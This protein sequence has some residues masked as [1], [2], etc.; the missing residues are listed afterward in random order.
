MCL[1]MIWYLT[2]VDAD[3]GGTWVVPWSHRDPRN[4]RGPVDN[5]CVAAPISGELQVAAPAGSVYIQD[6]RSWHASPLHNMGRPLCSLSGA[7]AA[8]AN[9]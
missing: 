4:P 8:A 6:S 2:D 7:R 1:V 5:I 9:S 3:S